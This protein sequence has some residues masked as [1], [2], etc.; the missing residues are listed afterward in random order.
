MIGKTVAHYEILEKLGGGGMG[1]VFKARDLKLD[2]WVALKFLPPHYVSDG[3]TNDR[4]LRERFVQEARASSALDHPN[5]GVIHE[6]G[7]TEEGETFIAMAYYEGETLRQ[8][9]ERGQLP[10][11]EAISIV[12]QIARGLSIA[13]EHGIVHRDIKPANLIVT[14]DGGVKII[15]FGLAKLQEV[16]RMTRQ[17]AIL[18]TP[19]Y[20]SPEQARGE[21]VDART[22][23]WSLGVVL[24]EMLTGQ[25]PFRGGHESAV[26]HAILHDQPRPPRDVR[27]EVSVGLERVLLRALEKDREAR[28]GSAEEFA[29]AVRGEASPPEARA[30]LGKR[31]ALGVVA[32]LLVASAGW[33]F[34]RSSKIRWAREEGLPEVLRL[35]SE[36]SYSEAYERAREVERYI[37]T[38]PS[39]SK[40][41]PEFSTHVSIETTPPGADVYMKRYESLEN[42]WDYLGQTPIERKR[43]PRGYF[44]W[45]VEKAGFQTIEQA[46]SS[47]PS[48]SNPFGDDIKIQ[49]TLDSQGTAPP[50]MVKVSGGAWFPTIS[51]LEHLP[52]VDLRE[53]WV[54]QY[55]VT[56]AHFKQFVDRGGYQKREYWTHPFVREKREVSWEDAMKEFRDATGRTG[57]STWELGNHPEGKG[58]HPVS[59]VSWYEAA[60]YCEFAG[61][62]LPTVYH[63]S[64]AAGTRAS[65]YVVPLSNI[66]GRRQGPDAVGSQPGM[67][68]FGAFDLAGNVKEWCSNEGRDGK[69]YILGG[70]WNENSYMFLDQ[71]AQS[72][73]DRSSAYGF[74][75]VKYLP[76]ST[77][78]AASTGLLLPAF[79]DYSKEKPVGDDVFAIYRRLYSYDKTP[80]NSVVEAVDE[81][82]DSWR[83]EKITFDAPYGRERV[84][85]YLFIPKKGKP[86]Y[87]TV[88][89]FPG[90]NVIELGSF[91]KE[92][93]WAYNFLIESGRAVLYP[94][95][96]STFERAADL[97][98]DPPAETSLYRDHVLIW[99]KELGRSIDYL[100]TR[101]DV[102]MEKLAYYGVSWGGSLIQLPAVEK[103]L[104]AN[105]LVGSGFYFTKAFSEVDQINFLPR[106]TA[107]VLV[108]NGRSDFFCPVETCLEPFYRLLGTPEADRRLVITDSGHGPPRNE[109]IRETLDW[110]DRYLGPVE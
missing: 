63:W 45:K 106:V 92:R 37:P 51:G 57:P 95:Y 47:G 27:N 42:D 18:G 32:V 110:L 2:R 19:S 25:V 59:G 43:I 34:Q 84:T 38:D 91:Q 13:H 35:V 11:E 29:K 22:D 71:D 72:P 23:L 105:V 52:P 93:N 68:P 101:D 44:R 96:K 85:A 80:L 99:A 66:D 28:F 73:W 87:Q 74:R 40:S 3:V 103:R 26:I 56:N 64:K 61:K 33:F 50:G 94:I 55:E 104:M 21:D 89:F 100:E 9:M 10:V 62:A 107:P 108:I 12:E 98:S 48:L 81:T 20:M 4:L 69:R 36:G 15:D 14:R 65:A 39:L 6:I 53:F 70:A 30:G 102:D 76:K 17:G 88:V 67:S 83:R 49:W 1:V 58:D 7:E 109:L 77:L 78:P 54:D 16:T 86:P 8:R 79:R 5:I 24:Y 41:W 46:G 31:V 60:A 90:S 97:K 75:C 82:H